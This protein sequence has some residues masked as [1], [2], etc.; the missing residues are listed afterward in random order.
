MTIANDRVSFAD[1]KY[2]MI[3]DRQKA[4]E[5]ALNQAKKGDMVIV[6]G[7]GHETYQEIKGVRYRMLDS[8]IIKD[9]NN[10]NKWR[11]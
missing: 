3:S 6:A 10:K 8:D 11:T 9:W 1:G 4:V 7:K 5:T 2:I